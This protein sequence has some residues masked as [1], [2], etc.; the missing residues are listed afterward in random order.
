M[1]KRYIMVAGVDYDFKGV[2]FSIFCKNR[3]KRIIAKNTSKQALHFTTF[4]IRK[5]KQT[6][7]DVSYPSGNKKETSS[8]PNPNKF[9]AVSKANYNGKVFKDGQSGII[10][11]MDIYKEVQTIGSKNA[12]SLMELSFFS[13]AWMGGPILVN[14]YDDGYFTQRVAGTTATK[15]IPLP[16]GSRDPDDLDPR[17]NKDF[18]SPNM[19]STEL[20][21]FQKA[22]HTN[23]F[24]WIWGCAFPKDVHQILYKIEK[25]PKYKSSG[26][27]DSTEFLFRYMNHGHVRLLESFLNITIP[28]KNN[29]KI[30]FVD[31][32]KFICKVSVASYSQILANSSKKNVIGGVMGTY[33]EYDKGRLPLMHV[34]KGFARHFTFYKNYMGFSFDKEGRK[35]G[36]YQPGKSCP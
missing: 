26:V 21:N 35:Y 19:S 13:H 4:D 15:K 9:K 17:G 34:Y 23:G 20:K 24:S 10:S 6:V 36:I 12:G 1:T 27:S 30:K 28:N 2:D 16:A 32:K 3:I 29:F 7:L 5:G 31:L 33:S 25:H 14:S 11:I 22:F 18:S 8:N